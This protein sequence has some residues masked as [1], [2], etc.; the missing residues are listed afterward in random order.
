MTG[1]LSVALAALVHA[2]SGGTLPAPEIL[3]ALAAFTVLAAAIASTVRMPFWAVMLLLGLCQQVLHLL[4]DAMASPLVNGSNPVP[5]GHHGGA[6]AASLAAVGAAMP[7]M[8]DP[9]L[10]SHGHIAAALLVALILRR[11]WA[12]PA[13]WRSHFPLDRYRTTRQG[14]QA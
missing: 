5:D 1:L 9:M 3:L 4:L 11:G 8:T 7:A 13:W 12:S 10:M 6:S 2:A 14:Q